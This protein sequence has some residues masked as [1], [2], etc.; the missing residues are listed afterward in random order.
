MPATR[1]KCP[2]GEVIFIPQ[3]LKQCRMEQRCLSRRTLRMVADQRPWNGEPSTTQLLK[4]TRE[5]YLE[6]T[7][8]DYAL[9]PMGELFRVLGSKAHAY[10]EEFTDNELSEERLRDNIAS[11][12]FDFYDPDEKALYDTKTWGSFKVARALGFTTERV[13]IPTG[14]FYKTGE[15]KGQPKTKKQTNIVQGKPDMPET[16][17]Q[18]NHYRM[19]LESAGFPV[20]KMF[21]EAIIR[22]GNTFTAKNRGIDMNGK[23]IP[24]RF[25][26]DEDVKAF[27]GQK[28]DNLLWALET[29][30]MP[31]PCSPDESWEGRKCKDYC[32][33][34]KFCDAGMEIKGGQLNGNTSEE[35]S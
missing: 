31:S 10:L 26:P 21:V 8:T 23:L 25:I 27:L 11:G 32:R 18:L 20:E 17:I 19:M 24:V 14:E 29:E 9:D 12:Q 33:V 6:I 7:E 30:T 1:F 22:D 3:C 13:D 15:K 16:E 35:S 4:G 2:D 34:A 5:A 28:R